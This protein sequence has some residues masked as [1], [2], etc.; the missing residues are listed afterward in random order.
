MNDKKNQ[1]AKAAKPEL[2]RFQVT[3][4]ANLLFFAFLCVL[5]VVSFFVCGAVWDDVESG[6]T[7]FIF[8]ILGGGFVLVSLLDYVYESYFTPAPQESQK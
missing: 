4:Y 7:E 3:F 8:F 5:W 1:N 6:L 2:T